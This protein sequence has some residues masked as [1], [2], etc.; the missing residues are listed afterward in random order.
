MINKKCIICDE[1]FFTKDDYRGRQKKTCS[2]TC[3]RKLGALNSQVMKN[4]IVCGKNTLTTKSNK[5][6]Y[7]INCVE[8]KMK[9]SYICVVCDKHFR[10]NKHNSKFCSRDCFDKSNKENLV[11]LEC[12]YCK[13][14]FK[15]PSFT[16]RRNS[17]VFCS[18]QCNNNQ[19]SI[20]NPT[21]YGGTWKRR[22][23]EIKNRDNNQCLLC[24]SKS[25]LQVHHFIK[26]L[27]FENPNDA[28]YDENTGTFC[29][30][31]HK[32]VEKKK[33]KSLS[34]FLKDIV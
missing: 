34:Q 30:S 7:C 14:K 23:K 19:Y 3:A 1:V 12:F 6:P 13:V 8:N 32:I 31:C 5:F 11:E 18:T 2:P 28:H 26:I 9:Y 4:C 16:V 21:R 15:R 33:Y 24:S 27:D 17:R 22:R 29:S 20:D 25:N 10:T